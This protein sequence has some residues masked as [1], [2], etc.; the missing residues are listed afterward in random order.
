MMVNVQQVY[1]SASTS[2]MISLMGRERRHDL[3][4]AESEE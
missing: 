1:T 2:A 3:L 4:D